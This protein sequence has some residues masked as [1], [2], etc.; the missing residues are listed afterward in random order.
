MLDDFLEGGLSMLRHKPK[1]QLEK[2]KEEAKSISNGSSGWLKFP[3]VD[4]SPIQEA[5]SGQAATGEKSDAT[6]V[7][8]TFVT[9]ARTGLVGC[10]AAA[11]SIVRI[12]PRSCCLSSTDAPH[13]VRLRGNRWLRVSQIL[14]GAIQ[15]KDRLL[16]QAEFVLGR[17]NPKPKNSPYKDG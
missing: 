15:V 13:V 10:I 1:S 6:I 3:L 11:D 2:Q 9:R 5:A 4:L 7:A 17:I 12:Q 14:S 16:A 8:Q